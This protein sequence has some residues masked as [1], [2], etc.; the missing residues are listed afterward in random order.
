MVWT[1]CAGNGRRTSHRKAVILSLARVVE[2]K[3]IVNRG[4]LF[5]AAASQEDFKR[6]VA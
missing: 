6:I 3:N 5:V 4:H 2:G 1:H